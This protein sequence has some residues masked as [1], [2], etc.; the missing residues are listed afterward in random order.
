MLETI[1]HHGGCFLGLKKTEF[2]VEKIID[3]LLERNI[4]QIYFIGASNTFK[5][6]AMIYEEIKRRK[7]RIGICVLLKAINKDVAIFD[8]CF[9]F[10]SAV[11]ETQRFIEMAY[12]SSKSYH[13]TVCKFFVTFSSGESARIGIRIF[14][15]R[16]S[17]SCQKC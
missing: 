10:E 14:G 6:A 13:N 11:E 12:V 16:C 8:T 3:S 5:S 15:V 2:H 9:G 7:L 17:Q 4:N 1:H